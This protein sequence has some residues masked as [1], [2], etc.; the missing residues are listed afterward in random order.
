MYLFQSAFFLVLIPGIRYRFRIVQRLQTPY[1][2]PGIPAQIFRHRIICPALCFRTRRTGIAYLSKLTR[3]ARGTDPYPRSPLH[4][5]F[6]GFGESC[7]CHRDTRF[8]QHD[9]G[10]HL[11][12][13]VNGIRTLSGTAGHLPR[14]RIP[15]RGMSCKLQ[16]LLPVLRKQLFA[17][18]SS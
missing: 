8:F 14:N 5:L 2:F 4:Y 7:L 18:L 3:T 6:P 16:S 11:P 15:F 17:H 12:L 9:T 10:S 1:R 13:P